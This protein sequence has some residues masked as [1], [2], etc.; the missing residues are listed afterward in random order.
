MKPESSSNKRVAITGLGMFCPVG[1]TRD[2]CWQN[3]L[4]GKSGI[5]PITR[6]DASECRTRIAGEL[7]PKYF[8]M[9]KDALPRR[10]YKRSVLPSRLSILSARQAIEDA[11]LDYG[12]IKHTP[13]GVITGCGGST[14]GD[15]DTLARQERK[16]IIF[17]HD[18]LNALSACV[19]IELGLSGPSFNM[20]TACASG[21]F[22]VG[23][24]YDYVKRS[25]ERCLAIGIETVLH[26]DT[27]DGFNQLMALSEENDEPEKASRP[28][29]KRRS[30]FVISEGACAILL[31]PVD[32]AAARGAPVYALISG[33]GLTS[34]AFNIVAPEPQ[35][36]QMAKAMELAIQDAG[37]TKEKIGYIN[38]HGTS[39][40]H[41]DVAE[42]KA[43][44]RVFGP[45]AG[46][47]AV[48]SI[49]SMIGH[50]IGAAGAIEVAVSALGL[51]HQI[52]L[53]TI[54]Y[55]VPDPQCDLDYVPNVARKVDSLEAVITNSFGF[56]GHNAA[57]VLQR[58]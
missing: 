52:L 44:K 21:A 55:E 22:A 5:R 15:N 23:F 8:E 34:E 51:Y 19:S 12:E 58:F 18:M 9:E 33:V 39:T 35:G 48:S 43:I 2:E 40:P 47:I 16:K 11:N 36:S 13:M 37:I 14:F 28:F 7:P 50:C 25:G 53:P 30:G 29:D 41:N 31:E 38:A 54:N 45:A 6:F 10:Y 26:K 17:S 24:A 4:A 20:A 27:I 46:N 1:I 3:M 49:K 57:I 42:T 56:G 32:I